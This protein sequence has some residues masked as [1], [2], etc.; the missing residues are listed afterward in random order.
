MPDAPE[1]P[2]PEE[3]APAEPVVEEPKKS[4]PL[5]EAEVRGGR[6]RGRRQ[7]MK[8]KVVKDEEGYLGKYLSVSFV[9]WIR[10]NT[11]STISDT[12]RARLG[13]VL[14]GR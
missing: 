7:V 4:E 11:C 3:E 12:G 14:G 2:P 5:E 8:K 1:S 13:R 9:C 6:R 10:I